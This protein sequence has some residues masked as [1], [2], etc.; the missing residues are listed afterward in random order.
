MKLFFVSFM[1]LAAMHVARAQ[2]YDRYMSYDDNIA[3]LKSVNGMEHSLKWSAV[4]E[5]LF[6]GSNSS[7][8]TIITY[9]P[10]LVINGVFVTIPDN[11]SAKQVEQMKSVVNQS[12]KYE[13]AMLD[14]PGK[15]WN[16]CRPFSGII[17][18]TIDEDIA[19]KLDKLLK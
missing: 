12:M 1:F 7:L 3:W 16:F 15:N 6:Q 13:L 18:L 19:R 9:C 10:A 2:S 11:L 5:R 14:D 17:V 8:D 4:Q